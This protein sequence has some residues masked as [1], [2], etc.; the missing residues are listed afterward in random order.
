MN[1]QIAKDIDEVVEEATAEE[2][3]DYLWNNHKEFA[4][5]LNNRLDIE[6]INEQIENKGKEDE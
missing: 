6:I 1:Y 4:I 5:A 2:V 3:A